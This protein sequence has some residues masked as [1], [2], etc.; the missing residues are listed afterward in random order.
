MSN[1]IKDKKSTPFSDVET[2]IKSDN[3]SKKKGNTPIKRGNSSNKRIKNKKSYRVDYRMPDGRRVTKVLQRKIDAEMFKAQLKVEK[4][5]FLTT[6]QIVKKDVTL[7]EFSKIWFEESVDGRKAP[8]TAHGYRSSL[9]IYIL[10][11]LGKIK[12]KFLDFNHSRKLENYILRSGKTNRTVNKHM[13]NFK[14]MMN[15]A[16]KMG[17]ILKNKVRGYKELKQKRRDLTYWNKGEVK[18]FLDYTEYNDHLHDLYVLTLNTGLRLG[19][20]C[21]LCW[22][23]V[24]FESNQIVIARSLTRNGLRDSTK[25]GETR[26][27]PMND[28]TRSVLLKRYRDKP[29]GPFVF[30]KLDGSPLPYDHINMRCFRPSQKKSGL[31]KIIRFHDLRH[32]YASHFVMNGGSI[33][34]LQK[35][36]GHKEIETTMIYAHLDKEFMEKA[37]KFVSF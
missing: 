7:E 23:K 34:T 1:Q 36:L 9:D 6:G 24:D 12:I 19:E 15:D 18:T 27:L 29:E 37:C 17:Y 14:T 20:V 10:P 25:S 21:G 33:Y 35:L 30:C 3:S 22:D 2:P 16:E 11:V 4:Q 26:Y 28:R 5:M 32:T 31:D 8:K 13:M